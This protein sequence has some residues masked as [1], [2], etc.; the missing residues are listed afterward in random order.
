MKAK[1][2][3]RL[4]SAKPRLPEAGS[5]AGALLKLGGFFLLLI[6]VCVATDHAIDGGL[7]RIRTS[8]F[9]GWN[10]VM[11]G[12]V[13]AQ[14][15]IS[16][17]SRAASHYDPRILRQRTG[18]T[19]FNIG[20]NGTQTDLQF[21]VLKAYLAH[22]RKPEVVIH[23][24]DAFSFVTSREVYDSVLYVPYLNDDGLYR[25]L[26]RMQPELWRSRYIPLYGYVVADMSFSWLRGLGAW[27]G[28]MPREDFVDGF[29]PRAKAW[30]DEFRHFHAANPDGVRWEIEKKGI[31][32]LEEMA[33]LCRQ[34]GIKFVLVYSPEYIE[35]QKM[36]R[37]REEIFR[38]FREI[39]SREQCLFLDFSSWRNSGDT[40][41][42]TNSQHLN[43][44]GASRFSNDLAL[45][46]NERLL[47]AGNRPGE[48]QLVR[49]TVAPAVLGRGA[50]K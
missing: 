25:D 19:A 45:A 1:L 43:A 30:T 44:E 21:A 37:N 34:R 46:L 40:R 49:T 16:G 33:A 6:L 29:D 12:E 50:A 8:R 5:P 38:R 39:A 15:V 4:L 22:N 24:L 10:R 7:R 42:F 36:T 26:S 35:M 27:L 17:S 31:A 47:H 48:A 41:Y 23:N 28:I 3:T 2:L 11:Q 13:N 9:G 14:L 18:L 20:R 32:L